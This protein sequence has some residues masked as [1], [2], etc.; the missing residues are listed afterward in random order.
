MWAAATVLF[1]GTS[2]KINFLKDENGSAAVIF[3]DGA[4]L[5]EF[6]TDSPSS[7]YYTCD[8][9]TY[10]S[11]TMP[12]GL[13]NITLLTSKPGFLFLQDFVVT[14]EVVQTDSAGNIV[15]SG[16]GTYPPSSTSSAGNSTVTGSSTPQ[17]HRSS[18]LA[19][20]GAIAGILIACGLAVAGIMYCRHRRIHGHQHYEADP[21][22][23][24]TPF[25]QGPVSVHSHPEENKTYGNLMGVNLTIEKI[26]SAAPHATFDL[27]G[28][29]GYTGE[30]VPPSPSVGSAHSPYSPQ[31]HLPSRVQT[32]PT[33][34]PTFPQPHVQPQARP[35]RQSVYD[36]RMG[37]AAASSTSL[38]AS[39]GVVQSSSTAHTAV[40]N[41]PSPSHPPRG[42]KGDDRGVVASRHDDGDDELPPPAYQ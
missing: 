28:T 29:M 35:T 24:A 41:M 18:G 21:S 25:V 13:H 9:S 33:R 40:G 39:H 30:Q 22:T 7:H 31:Q 17:A 20:G 37:L 12:N 32:Q 19:I 36:S 11:G 14:G 1:T 23:Y 5:L 10:T 6:P 15:P 2:V 42:G 38:P 8:Q 4:A 3:V 34:A 27:S 26:P 16:T